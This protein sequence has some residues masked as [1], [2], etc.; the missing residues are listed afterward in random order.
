MSKKTPYEDILIAQ[1]DKEQIIS[2]VREYKF[3]EDRRFR[4]D[5]AWPQFQIAVEVH[6]DVWHGGRHTSGVGFTR[7]REKMNLAII[8]GW[9][10]LEVTTGQVKD[11]SA[12]KWISALFDKRDFT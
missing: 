8:E 9:K 12:I 6:G 5:L 7:D 2:P 4:F 10:V 1:M 11:G 3:L